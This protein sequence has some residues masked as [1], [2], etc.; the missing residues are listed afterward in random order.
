M[1]LSP[2]EVLDIARQGAALGC[3]EALFTLGDRP[4]DRW[5]AGAGV[6]GRARLR[7]HAVVRAGD[8]GP[9]A[10]GDRAAAAPEPR[11][12]DAGRRSRGSSRWRP[13]GDDAGDDRRPAV[14]RAGRCALRLARTR[15]RRSGCG[16][17]RTP[18]GRRSRSRPGSSSASARPSPSGPSRCS[19]SAR[20]RAQYGGVQEVHRAELPGQA[21]HRDALDAGRRADEYLAA[22]AVAR[23]VLGPADAHPGAAEPVRPGELRA[24]AARRDRRLGRGVAADARPREPGAAL[25]ARRGPGRAHR[26]SRV[27]AA[28]AADR[29]PAVRAARGALAGP[30]GAAARRGR[31]PTRRPVWPRGRGAGRAG[32][33]GAGR[34]A[35]GLAAAPAASTCTAR[36]TPTGRTDDRRSDFDDVYGDW[37]VL[38]GTQAD[39]ATR[40][41]RRGWTPTCAP[42][43]AGRRA[44]RRRV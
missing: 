36:S 34:P 16:C 33:A 32:L 11:G 5:P 3:K 9:G 26:A 15:T 19:R 8:G 4:E 31:W 24:A 30:A 7:R 41:R 13:H 27:R 28:R 17:S 35:L 38:G 14:H 10:G 22:I 1:F 25:A 18:A 12:D 39:R 37:D 29:A 23:I 43:C 2:D 42:R 44:T 21:G 6:A 40:R 20:S